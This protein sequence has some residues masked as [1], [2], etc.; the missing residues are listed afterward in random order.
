M[1]GNYLMYVCMYVCMYTMILPLHFSVPI[2]SPWQKKK[3]KKLKKKKE[4]LGPC[5][6][7]NLY[8]SISI[9]VSVTKPKVVI[10]GPL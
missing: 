9:Y 4:A 8:V 3:K 2:Y 7:P 10:S 5:Q 6:G 1:G